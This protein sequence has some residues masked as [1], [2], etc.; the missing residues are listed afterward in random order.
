MNLKR[1]LILNLTELMKKNNFYLCTFFM[2]LSLSVFSQIGNNNFE[3][4]FDTGYKET[5]SDS[6]II[7]NYPEYADSR[8]CQSTNTYINDKKAAE[9]IYADGYRCGVLQASQAIIKIKNNTNSATIEKKQ[10]NLSIND[11]QD[12]IDLLKQKRLQGGDPQQVISSKIAA[13]ENEKSNLIYSNKANKQALK[14]QKE[15]IINSKETRDYE[16]QQANFNSNRV[17]YNNDL[18]KLKAQQESSRQNFYNEMNNSLNRLASSMQNVAMMQVYNNLKARQFTI[19]NFAN[20]NQQK[21]DKISIIY[22]S[23]PKENFNKVLSGTFK[24][25][26]ISSKKYSYAPNNELAYVEDCYVK[27]INNVITNIY[28]FGNK[29]IENTLPIEYPENS[30]IRNGFVKYIDLENLENFSV[31]LIEPY[32]KNANPNL[33]LK[34]NNVGHITIWSSDKNDVGK[35]VYI[36]ELYDNYTKLNREVAVKIQYAKNEKEIM[37]NPNAVKTSFNLNY[38]IFYL[39]EVTNTPYGRIPLATK[40]SNPRVN[41]KEL[42]PNEHRYV[43]IK[44]YRE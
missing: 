7:G 41:N 14:Q 1:P 35:I 40:V 18:Q 39:G 6:G 30:M 29:E 43:E 2:L 24:A 8:K 34:E 3:N 19:D 32:L 4:G 27:V 17:Q 10:G 42:E 9:K 5:L 22:N 25:Y 21:L 38:T 37:A 12:E 23:I 28:M 26:L 13:L 11:I 16:I 33:A 44:K 36:Q 15:D 31:I 20:V